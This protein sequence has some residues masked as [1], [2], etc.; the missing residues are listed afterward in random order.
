MLEQNNIFEK[1]RNNNPSLKSIVTHL[2]NKSDLKT[3][4]KFKKI[5]DSILKTSKPSL[6]DP[7]ELDLKQLPDYLQYAF[8]EKDSKL[9]VISASDSSQEQRDKLLFVLG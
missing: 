1:E 5:E 7:P 8:L 3:E 4:K 6:E 9:L 2:D